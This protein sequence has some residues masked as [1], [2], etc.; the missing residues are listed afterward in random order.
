MN[1]FYA[2]IAPFNIYAEKSKMEG[3]KDLKKV[4]FFI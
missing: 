2:K 3:E 1:D 4:F